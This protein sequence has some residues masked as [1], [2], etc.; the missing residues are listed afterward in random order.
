MKNRLKMLHECYMHEKERCNVETESDRHLAMMT[1]LIAEMWYIN[2][3]MDKPE[4]YLRIESTYEKDHC[5]INDEPLT[6]E[7]ATEWVGRMEP[8]GG[9]TWKPWTTAETTK[10]LADRRVKLGTLSAWC[11]NA[12][13]N[14]IWSDSPSMNEEEVL[15]EAK[16]YVQDPDVIPAH[17]RLGVYYRYIVK[18]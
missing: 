15:K 5:S 2:E 18:H 12:L 11:C 10:M 6:R 13:L 1:N 17:Q 14:M 16:K 3:M 4:H 7:E 9:G 8:T